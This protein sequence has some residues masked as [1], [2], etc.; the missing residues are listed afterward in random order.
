MESL[1]S[2]WWRWWRSCFLFLQ[3]NTPNPSPKNNQEWHGTPQI[4]CKFPRLPYQFLLF[5][6]VSFCW[7][8]GL[9]RL[10]SFSSSWIENPPRGNRLTGAVSHFEVS[11]CISFVF[12]GL[13]R[14]L[15]FQPTSFSGEFFKENGCVWIN[16]SFAG[17]YI[18][19]I[20]WSTARSNQWV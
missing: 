19:K 16:Y 2:W 6:V 10:S 12:G 8:V 4:S 7:P 13:K 11:K 15:C 17:D 9:F 1:C 5:A 20:T 18:F 14:V 3:T